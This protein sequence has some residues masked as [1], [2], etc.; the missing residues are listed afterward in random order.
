M[1]MFF[2][3]EVIQPSFFPLLISAPGYD[4]GQMFYMGCIW[5][6]MPSTRAHVCY[7]V[8]VEWMKYD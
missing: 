2:F 8:S 4:A 7:L 3:T 5:A 6:D 1:G